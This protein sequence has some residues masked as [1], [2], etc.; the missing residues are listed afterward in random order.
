ME[1]IKTKKAF[2][3]P[4]TWEV[5]GTVEVEADSKEEALVKFREEIDYFSLPTESYY[6]DDSFKESSESNEEMLSMI[7]EIDI[8]R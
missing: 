5:Y 7:E 8:M 6:V 1:N 4:V 2:K 3:I